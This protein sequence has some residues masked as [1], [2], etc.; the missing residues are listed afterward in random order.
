MKDQ[1]LMIY[2]AVSFHQNYRYQSQRYVTHLD[3]MVMPF[4]LNTYISFQIL[5]SV[6]LNNDDNDDKKNGFALKMIK[7]I[8]KN[9]LGLSWTKLKFCLIRVVEEV[10][11]DII[12]GVHYLPGWWL[13]SDFT[14]LLLMLI[15]T[16][17]EV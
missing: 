10:Y 3:R 9:K 8:G 4:V 15:S 12:V 16:Q 13:G 2:Q 11:V 17:V 7:I 14:K 5:S 6:Q 1:K